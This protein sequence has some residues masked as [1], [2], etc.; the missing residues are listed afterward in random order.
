MILLPQAHKIT[1]QLILIRRKEGKI[2]KKEGKIHYD[3]GE[4]R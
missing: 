2:H 1:L 3:G 4:I